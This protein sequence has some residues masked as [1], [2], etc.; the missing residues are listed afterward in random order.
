MQRTFPSAPRLRFKTGAVDIRGWRV[1]RRESTRRFVTAGRLETRAQL[2]PGPRD[3]A[4]M[5]TPSG[6]RCCT[7]L[8]CLSERG[9]G[10]RR[11]DQCAYCL[12]GEGRVNP[13]QNDA[14]TISLDIG[15]K[16]PFRTA[17]AISSDAC[18]RP[19]LSVAEARVCGPTP[20]E[21]SDDFPRGDQTL[22]AVRN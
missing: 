22:R 3:R 20:A 21:I 1:P 7:A 16:V 4:T 2:G 19:P 14:I 6:D 8:Y 17:P 5:W 18:L 11:G 13:A 10:W 15:Q 12:H 9:W